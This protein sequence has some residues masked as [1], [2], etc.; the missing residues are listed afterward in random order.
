MPNRMSETLP[1]GTVEVPGYAERL[2]AAAQYTRDCHEL[3]KNSLRARNSV[4][5]EAID[6]GYAGH[7]AARDTKL[8]QPHIIRILS[9]S[10]P[11][12]G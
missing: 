4:I 12:I 5:V 10:D 6:H 8:A 7:Q 3:W 11:E 2:R 1:A 9:N